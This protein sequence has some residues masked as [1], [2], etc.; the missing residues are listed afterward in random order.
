MAR[1]NLHNYPTFMSPFN[2]RKEN[3]IARLTGSLAN[4]LLVSISPLE[5]VHDS[6]TVNIN[7][8]FLPI[9]SS[10]SCIAVAALYFTPSLNKYCIDPNSQNAIPCVI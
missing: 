10:I 2:T 1:L 8:P 5:F 7:D 6:L 9:P 4:C 3:M